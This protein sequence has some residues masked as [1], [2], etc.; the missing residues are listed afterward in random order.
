VICCLRSGIGR[1]S[2]WWPRSMTV[3]R[4]RVGPPALGRAALPGD[5]PLTSWRSPG[6]RPSHGDGGRPRGA[7]PNTRN[8]H[9]KSLQRAPARLIDLSLNGLETRT[10][11]GPAGDQ[12]MKAPHEWLVHCQG[13]RLNL[14]RE[15][16]S[17]SCERLGRSQDA[18]A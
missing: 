3:A 4:P 16:I 11:G 2:S 6:R 15:K 7:Q 18:P 12:I 10:A 14:P 9:G 13:L 1:V 8:T 17:L 5:E